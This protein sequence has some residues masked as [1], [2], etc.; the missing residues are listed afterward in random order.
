M[1][2]SHIVGLLSNVYGGDTSVE[3]QGVVG[4]DSGASLRCRAQG[5]R[6]LCLGVHASAVNFGS[7]VLL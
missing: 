3:D 5:I 6:A 4:S 1:K 2:L 7:R